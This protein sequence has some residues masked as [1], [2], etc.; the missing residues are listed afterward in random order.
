M[1]FNLPN[2]SLFLI[3]IILESSLKKYFLSIYV[4]RFFQ[5]CFLSR[6]NK[7]S[8]NELRWI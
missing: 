7:I 2:L 1:R 5:L 6:E 4:F 3:I 8:L